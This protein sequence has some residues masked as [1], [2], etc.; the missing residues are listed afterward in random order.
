MENNT[1]EIRLLIWSPSNVVVIQSNIRG[2]AKGKYAFSNQLKIRGDFFTL[3]VSTQ[4]AQLIISSLMNPIR[5][6]EDTSEKQN[7]AHYFAHE[8]HLH[9]FKFHQSILRSDLPSNKANKCLD[10][11]AFA[12]LALSAWQ[13]KRSLDNYCFQDRECANRICHCRFVPLRAD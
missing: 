1:G 13:M 4:T 9:H 5:S 6:P 8:I 11:R 10:R 2:L 12:S 3:Q 7:D